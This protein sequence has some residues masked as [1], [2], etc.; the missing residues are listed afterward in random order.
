MARNKKLA[1]KFVNQNYKFR[2]LIKSERTTIR[3]LKKGLY[4]KPRFWV[5]ERR[6]TDLMVR[7]VGRR[8]RVSETVLLRLQ[9]LQK[10][11]LNNTSPLK[12][13]QQRRQ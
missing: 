1:K 4:D 12:M 10:R 3:T 7:K 11:L 9:K 6:A 5:A 8:R 13:R 2:K